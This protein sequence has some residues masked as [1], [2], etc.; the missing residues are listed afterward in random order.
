MDPKALFSAE[1]AF[2]C[3]AEDF[4]LTGNVS[5]RRPTLLR[6]GNLRQFQP[7]LPH[8]DGNLFLIAYCGNFVVSPLS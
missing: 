1:Q 7:F 6:D 3:Q 4:Y 5:L 8:K 2:P